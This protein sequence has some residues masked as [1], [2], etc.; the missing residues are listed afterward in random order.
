MVRNA[1]RPLLCL[2]RSGVTDWDVEKHTTTTTLARI[3]NSTTVGSCFG[4]KIQSFSP[5]LANEKIP[6]IKLTKC[7]L[8]LG[9]KE[10]KHEYKID[11]KWPKT[12]QNLDSKLTKN[13][14]DFQKIHPNYLDPLDP[15][16]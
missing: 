6:H 3:S 9:L 2:L 11:Q 15:E 4:A 1:F 7:D 14:E 8:K 13:R 5:K 10:I 16:I 12:C